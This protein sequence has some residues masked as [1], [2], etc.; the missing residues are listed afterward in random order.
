MTHCPQCDAKIDESMSFCEACGTA[1]DWAAQQELASQVEPSEQDVQ[2]EPASQMASVEPNMQEQELDNEPPIVSPTKSK[3]KKQ[4]QP[5][6]VKKLAIFSTIGVLLISIATV[7]TLSWIALPSPQKW[8]NTT[9]EAFLNG[10]TQTFYD[11]FSKPAPM[12]SNAETFYAEMASE[13][14]AI[15]QK[16]QQDISKGKSYA[17]FQ[18]SEGRDILELRVV[19]KWGMT[20]VT[21]RYFPVEVTIVASKKHQTITLQDIELFSVHDNEAFTLYAVPGSYSIEITHKGQTENKMIILQ[22][23]EAHQHILGD[24]S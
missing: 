11:A 23:N 6:D 16:L 14:P 17:T 22:S 21:M 9:N 13:W 3:P 7:F 20:D 18:N 5:I 15:T 24:A 19:K 8:L 4:R 10:D 2:P 1:L 12:I